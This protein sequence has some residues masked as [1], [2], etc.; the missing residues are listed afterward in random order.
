MKITVDGQLVDGERVDF[1]PI[2]EPWTKHQLA[3]GTVIRIKLVVA[4]IVKVPTNN[5]PNSEPRY[6]VK[7]SNMLS[8]DAPE[9]QTEVH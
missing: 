8:V 6:V 5:K 9:S 7:S 1:T 3:D 2:N 4:D